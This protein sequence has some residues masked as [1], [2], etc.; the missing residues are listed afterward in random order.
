MGW[1]AEGMRVCAGLGVPLWQLHGQSICVASVSTLLRGTAALCTPATC[2]EQTA[3][4][5]ANF[6]VSTTSFW[7]NSPPSSLGSL[8]ASL[9]RLGLLSLVSSASPTRSWVTTW[10]FHKAQNE[11]SSLRSLFTPEKIE[12]G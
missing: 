11:G 1:E 9:P 5:S 7:A 2:S 8:W 6:K 4:R 10:I 12:N 3:Q